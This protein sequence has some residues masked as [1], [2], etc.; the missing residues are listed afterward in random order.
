MRI[1]KIDNCRLCPHFYRSARHMPRNVPVCRKTSQE[2]PHTTWK[3]GRGNI[4]A[5]PTYEI[6]E[7]CPLEKGVEN[8]N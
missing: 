4:F 1:V 6:P 8:E 5:E 3:S 7:N 2:L